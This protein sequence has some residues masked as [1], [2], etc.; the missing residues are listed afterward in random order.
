MNK[1]FKDIGVD[2]GTRI[3]KTSEVKIETLEAVHQKW[4]WDGI[5]GESI[6]F[7]NEDVVDL[8]EEEIKTMVQKTDYLELG[9]QITFKKAEK[10]TFVNFN[11]DAE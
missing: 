6:I 1:K 3:I 4:S 7:F 11:F 9:S 2:E 10:Y 8:N 5:Y